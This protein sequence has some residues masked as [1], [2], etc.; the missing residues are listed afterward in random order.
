M[1]LRKI[2]YILT[3]NTAEVADGLQSIAAHPHPSPLKIAH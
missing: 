3:R 1:S 2:T